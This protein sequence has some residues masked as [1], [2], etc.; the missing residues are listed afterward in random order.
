MLEAENAAR[1]AYG[2]ECACLRTVHLWK[3]NQN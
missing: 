1:T 3:K 2:H